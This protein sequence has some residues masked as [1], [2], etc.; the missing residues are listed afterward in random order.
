M[1]YGVAALRVPARTPRFHAEIAWGGGMRRS[2]T[3]QIVAGNGRYYGSA[4]PVA[5]DAAID[6]ARLGL[7]SL[8][9][10]TRTPRD[11]D[12]D[13]EIGARPPARFRVVPGAVE[14]FAPAP[15]AA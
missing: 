4:L 13:G 8:E 6:D 12:V 5:E 9:V 15:G 14:V 10:R 1:A 3:V 11:I 7:N 2:R